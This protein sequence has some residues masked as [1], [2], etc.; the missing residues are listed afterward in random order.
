MTLDPFWVR[1][2]EDTEIDFTCTFTTNSKRILMMRLGPE[3]NAGYSS[4]VTS[5][6]RTYTL[7]STLGR[8]KCEI[9]DQSD[10]V[11]A[12]V[13]AATSE[14]TTEQHAPKPN[15]IMCININLSSRN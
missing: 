5:L 9:L 14:T 2:C 15:K 11:W 7:N 6:S 12:T 8:I 1:D 3:S 4:H 10:L 13:Y